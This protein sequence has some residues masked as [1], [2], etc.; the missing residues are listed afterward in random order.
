VAEAESPSERPVAVIVYVP[1]VVEVT[2]NDADKVP[3]EIEQLK[4]PT[5]LPDNE[6]LVSLVEKSD[7]VA[8]TVAPIWADVGLNVIDGGGTVKLADAESPVWV[9]VTVTV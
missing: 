3:F 7:P 5:G 6:Q 1:G 9:P 4:V 2:L 8:S